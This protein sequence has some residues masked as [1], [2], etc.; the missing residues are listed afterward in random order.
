LIS[1]ELNAAVQE[2]T[3]IL[4]HSPTTKVKKSP[5]EPN[6]T[7]NPNPNDMNTQINPATGAVTLT[8]PLNITISLGGEPGIVVPSIR[9]DT[10]LSPESNSLDEASIVIDQDYSARKGFDENFLSVPVPLPKLSDDQLE[11]VARLTDSEDYVLKY[12]HFSIVMNKE[13]KM[14]FFTAVNIDGKS[15]NAIKSEIPSRKNIGG[16]R[17]YIDPRIEVD[18]KK[19]AFQIPAKFYAGND[20]DIGHQVRREDPIWGKPVSFALAC[21]NDTFHLT[22]ACPQHRNFNQGIPDPDNPK[23]KNV[24][25]KILWQGLENYLLDNARANNL[26]VNLFTGPVLN[27]KDKEYH[28]T[29]VCIPKAFWKVVVMKLANGKLSAT[30]YLVSQKDQLNEMEEFTFG[31][32]LFYQ[33]PIKKLEQL[34]GLSFGLT[35]YDPLAHSPVNAKES[36]NVMEAEQ[37][38][39]ALESLK[40]I[41]WEKAEAD[42]ANEPNFE[43][44]ILANNCNVDEL[45]INGTVVDNPQATGKVYVPVFASLIYYSLDA[46]LSQ[47]DGNGSLQLK[48]LP[49]GKN[50]S[51]SPLDFS[52]NTTTAK[53]GIK[54]TNAN[55]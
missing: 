2:S 19:P 12:H 33:V 4:G 15:Y 27:T 41:R 22:N 36:L 13:R 23:Y 34:T 14:A 1:H 39:H 5:V 18:P 31:S 17:W 46:S 51:Q 45:D 7:A 16:D 50:L 47:P 9:A 11:L 43:Y 49:S 32:F 8:V 55:L 30:G 6:T 25:G 24:S 10:A 20:F 44:T 40:D 38:L 21:N 3:K 48:Y 54:V 29:G 53:G 35:K 26:K 52:F 37:D 42:E 28:D